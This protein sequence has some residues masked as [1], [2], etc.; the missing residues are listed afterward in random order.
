ML[1]ILNIF[2]CRTKELQSNMDFFSSLKIHIKWNDQDKKMQFEFTRP[3][4]KTLKAFLLDFRHFCSLSSQVDF[5]TVSN[6]L[7][8]EHRAKELDFSK[9]EKYR[10]SWKKLLKSEDGM[11]VEFN[12]ADL[13][14]GKGLLDLMLN[15]NYFHLDESKSSKLD[16]IKN[17]SAETFLLFNFLN[18]VQK[19]SGLVI[20]FN[21]Q[22]VVNL[23]KH[24]R[25]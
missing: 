1:K 8:K 20:S 14:S 7:I 23:L 12:G 5:L 10:D 9:I 2:D 4:E 16:L 18:L 24:E 21:S 17:T 25:N 19:L 6:S 11:K 22:V 15:G 13:D 3:D